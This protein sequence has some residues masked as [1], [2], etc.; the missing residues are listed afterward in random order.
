M[1]KTISSKSDKIEAVEKQLIQIEK[2]IIDKSNDIYDKS[3]KDLDKRAQTLEN[4]HKKIKIEVDKQNK[5]IGK[6]VLISGGA[7]ALMALFVKYI[8]KIGY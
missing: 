8:P 4:E 5:F 3:K 2:A 7:G 1:D 6:L